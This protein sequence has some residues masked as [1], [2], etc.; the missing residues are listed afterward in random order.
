MGIPEKELSVVGLLQTNG[1][2]KPT[3]GSIIWANNPL[4]PPPLPV[5]WLWVEFQR[6]VLHGILENDWNPG[7]Y[8]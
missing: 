7:S 2:Y 6:N 4:S 1:P 3:P 8:E 5:M